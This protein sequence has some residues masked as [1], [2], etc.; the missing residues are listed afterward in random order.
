MT[1]SREGAGDFSGGYSGGVTPVPV[2]NTVVKASSA[3]GTAPEKEWESRTLP[4][5]T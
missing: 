1:R 4:E 3:D 5:I 2:P